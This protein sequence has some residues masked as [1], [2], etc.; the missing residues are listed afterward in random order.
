[1]VKQ[2]KCIT[3]LDPSSLQRGWTYAS[4]TL[5]DIDLTDSPGGGHGTAVGIIA[6]G[7]TRG[8]ASRA[9]LHLIKFLD[10]FNNP[11]PDGPR[12]WDYHVT[13]AAFIDAMR[14]V[15]DLVT[16][17]STEYPPAK[18]VISLTA[19]KSPPPRPQIGLELPLT[20]CAN[21]PATH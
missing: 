13:R 20:K 5:D 6:G 2:E 16:T 10:G 21:H 11:T 3:R 15:Y 14:H 9:N 19:S 12:I 18:S 17:R 1:M 8:V 4:R 7:R